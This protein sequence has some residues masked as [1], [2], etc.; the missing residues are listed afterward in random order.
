MC[1]TGTGTHITRD[2]CVPEKGTHITSDM[3]G[4]VREHISIRISVSQVVIS[5]PGQGNTY[6]QGYHCY[7]TVI[8]VPPSLVKCVS[9]TKKEVI[10]VLL[11]GKHV[12]CFRVKEHIPL[13]ICVSQVGEHS[14][15]VVSLPLP[16]KQISLVICVPYL[17]NAYRFNSSDRGTHFT[18]DMC[19]PGRDRFTL[20]QSSTYSRTYFRIYSCLQI[21][22]TGMFF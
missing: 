16:K 4:M 13:R 6:H 20:S 21:L 15:L 2:M 11:P 7:V 5:V 19:F 18:S 10:C 17:G 1:S 8:C 22:S 3:C 9:P 14:S 12:S